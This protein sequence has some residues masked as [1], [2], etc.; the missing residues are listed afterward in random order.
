MDLGLCLVLSQQSNLGLSH[1]VEK[2][3]ERHP[4]ITAC[5]TPRE[6]GGAGGTWHVA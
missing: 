6:F 1:L 3:G 2:E 4:C 5:C